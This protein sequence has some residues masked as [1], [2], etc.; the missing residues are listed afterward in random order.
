MIVTSS[1][2]LFVDS[3]YSKL[4][5]KKAVSD[6]IVGFASKSIIDPFFINLIVGY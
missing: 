1:I 3:S 4:E 5:F 6:E 2:I